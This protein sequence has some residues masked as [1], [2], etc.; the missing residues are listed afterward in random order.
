MILT[1][2]GILIFLLMFLRFLVTMVNMLS[3]PY[4]PDP[5]GEYGHL[6]SLSVLIP[7]RNEERNIGILLGSLAALKYENAEILV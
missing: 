5:D 4:L 2:T 6:P 7:V 1:I 3:R